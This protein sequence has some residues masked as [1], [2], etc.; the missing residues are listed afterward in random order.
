[1]ATCNDRNDEKDDN[2]CKRRRKTGCGQYSP[3]DEGSILV[4]DGRRYM[5]YN[6]I[7]GKMEKMAICMDIMPIW[8]LKMVTI[9]DKVDCLPGCLIDAHGKVEPWY[10]PTQWLQSEIA[11]AKQEYNSL[12]QLLH[13]DGRYMRRFRDLVWTKTNCGLY[14][15]RVPFDRVEHCIKTYLMEMG[16]KEEWI[17]KCLRAKTTNHFDF[18]EVEKERSRDHCNF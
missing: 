6:K 17:D 15:P 1:M 11:G 5:D 2:T 7:P 16:W 12:A 10:Y 8:F 9:I 13:P 3:F 4:V 14:L 18:E